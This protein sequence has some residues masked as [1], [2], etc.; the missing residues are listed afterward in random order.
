MVSKVYVVTQS[1]AM[2]DEDEKSEGNAK[3]QSSDSMK[4]IDKYILNIGSEMVSRVM[5]VESQ[6]EREDSCEDRL[7]CN[8]NN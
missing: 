4:A 6:N 8:K 2:I 7:M 5:T 1:P 3:V